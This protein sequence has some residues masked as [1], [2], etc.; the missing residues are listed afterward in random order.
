MG[1]VKNKGIQ[2]VK[3]IL[4]L[5]LLRLIALHYQVPKYFVTK[6]HIYLK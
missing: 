6:S 5:F 4:F 2:V 1:R 3:K